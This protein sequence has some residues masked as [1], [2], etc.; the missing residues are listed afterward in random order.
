MAELKQS[1]IDEKAE[2]NSTFSD[3]PKSAELENQGNTQRP[4]TRLGSNH[5]QKP[6]TDEHTYRLPN[7][8]KTNANLHTRALFDFWAFVELMA[9]RGGCDNFA[10]F[11]KEMSDF[12]TT[13][14][15]TDINV[16]RRLG[17]VPRGHLKSTL[18]TVGYILWRV[19]RNENIRICVATAT[20]DLA[21]QFIR[22]VKQYLESESYQDEIWNNRPHVDGRLIPILDKAGWSRRNQQWDLGTYTESQ[23]KKVVWR[24]DALQVMRSETYKEPTVLAAS[25]G[26]NITGMH[27]DLMIL[28]DISNEET[29]AT[30]DKRDKTLR[31]ASDL[32][33]II[34]P[35]RSVTMGQLKGKG[36]KTTPLKEFVG[37]ELVVWGTRYHSEDY[38]AYLLENLEEFEYTLFFRNVY[39]NGVDS[40][41]GYLW[42]ERFTDKVVSRIQKRQGTIKF[43]SQYLNKVVT[44]EEIIFE[45]EKINYFVPSQI[46]LENSPNGYVRIHIG[47]KLIDIRPYLVVDPAIS[48][49][50]DADNSVVL[51]GGIDYER[52][53]YML[54]FIC[55]KMLPNILID[56]IYNLADKYKMNVAHIEVVA[57][58]QALIYMV[59]QKFNEYRPLA[60]KEYRPKGDKEARITTNL[61]PLFYNGQVYMPVWA[62]THKE[63]QNELAFFPTVHDDILDAMSMCVE[64]AVPSVSPKKKRIRDNFIVD[65]R[66]G[67]RAR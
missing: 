26:S 22:E 63:L 14:Q 11:H 40:S 54:D 19:Y 18:G 10:A 27:F 42:G 1:V 31:W 16:R 50:K 57:F 13:T 44:S 30:E 38:Y 6:N 49:K 61:Q 28:D 58:Q 8:W 51:V 34:D 37:D 46:D 48:Q 67:G 5:Y 3:D 65:R 60:L 4:K 33:S 2:H 52:N 62:K 21:Y 55:G 66:Y 45:E 64:L 23:D 29:V 41:D 53:F 39:A 20:R 7:N 35:E 59:K 47:E 43:A 17:L 25:P 32:E 24:A 12:F 36:K 15:A 9:Y 56:N